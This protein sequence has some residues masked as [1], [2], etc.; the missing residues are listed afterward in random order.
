VSL[1]ENE[2]TSQ[3]IRGQNEQVADIEDAHFD[4]K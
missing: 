2:S 1:E 3:T 4:I